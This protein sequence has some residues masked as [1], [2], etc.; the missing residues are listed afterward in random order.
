MIGCE[1]F[2]F[3]TTERAETILDQNYFAKQHDFPDRQTVKDAESPQTCID[4]LVGGM[5]V[6]CG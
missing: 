1:S 6:S 2:H 3:R 4:V 5:H